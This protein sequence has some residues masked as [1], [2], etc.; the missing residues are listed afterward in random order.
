MARRF[1]NGKIGV[2]ILGMLC[3]RCG[4]ELPDVAQFCL[5]CG[6]VVSA[7]PA[8]APTAVRMTD[9]V[10]VVL[11][12]PWDQPKAIR[13]YRWGIFQGWSLILGLPLLAVVGFATGSTENDYNAAWGW[14]IGSILAVPMGIGIVKKRRYGLIMVYATL[15]LLCLSIVVNFVRNGP[16]GA[17]SAASGA[18]IWV[19]ST[20][21]YHKRRDEFSPGSRKFPFIAISAGPN[22]STEKMTRK[23]WTIAIFMLGILLAAFNW[24][25]GVAVALALLV[26]STKD[27]GAENQERSSLGLYLGVILLMANSLL[28]FVIRR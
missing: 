4:Q 12:A 18:G 28:W 16:A 25:I 6:S 3:G 27:L 13:P 2:N 14:A 21:Y 19:A 22:F 26:R 15:G 20:I 11:P 5:K 10:G 9:R 8:P 23:Q 1:P 7:V 24:W 17:L